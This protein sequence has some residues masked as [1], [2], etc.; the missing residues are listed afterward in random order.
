MF[1]FRHRLPDRYGGP[2][3]AVQALGSA[4][5]RA[6]QER[7]AEEA[8]EEKQEHQQQAV[9]EHWKDRVTRMHEGWRRS[10]YEDPAKAAAYELI[11][12]P[13]ES[14]FRGN[15]PANRI[16]RFPPE[17]AMALFDFLYPDPEHLL[18]AGRVLPGREHCVFASARAGLIGAPE[19]ED[20]EAHAREEEPD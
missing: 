14:E 11:F 8:A 7:E 5:A 2:K 9:H 1:H 20:G 3:D 13:E 4:A 16:I 10:L 18:A 15:G 17:I 6:R 12:G 19:G